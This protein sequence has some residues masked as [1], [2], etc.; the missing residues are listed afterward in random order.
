MT[1]KEKQEG[2]MDVQAR[3]YRKL[4]GVALAKNSCKS[5]MCN[6]D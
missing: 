3:V 1:K 6:Y 2:R 4:Q 5:D